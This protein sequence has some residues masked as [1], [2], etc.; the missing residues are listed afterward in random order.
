[1]VPPKLEPGVLLAEDLDALRK[2]GGLTWELVS[3]PKYEVI[4][5]DT[6]PLMPV[7]DFG[8]SKVIITICEVQ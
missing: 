8:Q 4:G 5:R 3:Q 1:M 2:L 6:A 7:D